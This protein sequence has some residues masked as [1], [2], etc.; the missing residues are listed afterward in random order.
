[1]NNSVEVSSTQALRAVLLILLFVLASCSLWRSQQ[2]Q[3]YVSDRFQPWFRDLFPFLKTSSTDAQAQYHQLPIPAA[4]FS[5]GVAALAQGMSIEVLAYATDGSLLQQDFT[6][7]QVAGLLDSRQTVLLAL[8]AEDARL[9]EDML[10]SET[11]KLSYRLLP[12]PTGTLAG[13]VARPEA[14]TPTTLPDD[15]YRPVAIA[16]TELSAGLPVASLRNYV[17]APD[18]RVQLV[19][20]HETGTDPNK[21]QNTETYTNVLVLDLLDA[22]GTPIGSNVAVPQ[23]VLLSVPEIRFDALAKRLV[24]KKAVYLLAQPEPTAATTL[25]EATATPTAVPEFVFGVPTT[26]TIHSEIDGLSVGDRVVLLVV[27]QE[28]DL[29]GKV[30]KHVAHQFEATVKEP[31]PT[32]PGVLSISLPLK[33]DDAEP[34]KGFA[35]LLASE[36]VRIHV[37]KLDVEEPEEQ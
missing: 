30:L 7:V 8:P 5:P 28:K 15:G 4:K 10:M 13:Q 21:I 24:N 20:I 25:P 34:A 2:P 14:A 6:Q 26:I 35:A 22:N 27:V 1:M 36:S 29:E 17:G 9:L 33:A 12:P 37:L 32:I 11:V 23:T 16:V 19:T 31:S 18:K 3:G